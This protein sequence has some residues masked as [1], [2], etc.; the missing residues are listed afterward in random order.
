MAGKDFETSLRDDNLPSCSFM[1]P[2]DSS[3]AA[4]FISYST[5]VLLAI[6]VPFFVT[7]SSMFTMSLMITQPMIVKAASG[8]WC[9]C[10]SHSLLLFPSSLSPGS[11]QGVMISLSRVNSH[12]G[13]HQLLFLDALHEE[14]LYVRR[15]YTRHLYK[16]FLSLTSIL[17]PSFVVELAHKIVFFK[18]IDRV[19]K[20]TAFPIPVDLPVLASSAMVSWVYRTGVTC[21][22]QILRFEGFHE[23]LE[24]EGCGSD[25]AGLIFDEHMRIRRQ[26]STIS[27]RFRFFI[28]AC[29]VTI[30]ASQ[31]GALWLIFQAKSPRTFFNS[32]G[33]LVLY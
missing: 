29:L 31:L 28:I 2:S 16:A 18:T 1:P 32:G 11:S 12:G 20:I 24:S 17:V 27:H 6:I 4:T 33:L 5:F 13:L 9:R 19:N 22:F 10:L 15:A 23:L 30:T 14:R 26:L 7:T 8:S 21:E 25:V 3:C